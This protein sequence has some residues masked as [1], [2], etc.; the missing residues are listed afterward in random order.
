ML[1]LVGTVLGVVALARAVT[2]GNSPERAAAP[3][4]VTPT[5]SASPT[6]SPSPGYQPVACE[7][8][9]LEITDRT[10]V[11]NVPVGAPVPVDLVLANGGTVPCLLDAGPAALGV[12]IYSGADRIWSSLDCPEEGVPAERRLL[13]DV[14]STVD[15]GLTWDQV[16]SAPGCPEGQAAAQPGSYRAVVTI[17][18]G[19]SAALS[20][21]RAFAIE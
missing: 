16:R 3:P 9:V 13:L 14:G 11:A 18:G 19:G 10:P 8:G 21:A 12:V 15:L 5:A 20:W 7:A 1:V 17:D 2:G 6:A 4:S